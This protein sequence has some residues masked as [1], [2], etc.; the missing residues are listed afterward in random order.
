TAVIEPT[1][2]LDPTPAPVLDDRTRR[3]LALGLPVRFMPGP[4]EPDTHAAIAARLTE[5]P[6]AAEPELG[7]GSI[8]VLV[9]A[10]ADGLQVGESLTRTWGLP[11]STVV[12][13]DGGS[14]SGMGS[15]R[16]RILDAEALA[17]R[18]TSARRR[19]LPLVL[20][21][22]DDIAIASTTRTSRATTWG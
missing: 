20:V 13:A 18:A 21:V 5:L 3:L 16:Q 10:V 6:R 1:P 8:V 7:P 9:G 19:G 15:E 11:A 12:L 14:A 17:T 22:P 4:N 2:V